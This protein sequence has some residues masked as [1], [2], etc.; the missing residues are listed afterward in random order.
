M[1][2]SQG[3]VA[4]PVGLACCSASVRQ[5]RTFTHY[6][7]HNEFKFFLANIHH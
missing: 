2:N 3:A 5:T 7:M 6:A 4:F 1:F